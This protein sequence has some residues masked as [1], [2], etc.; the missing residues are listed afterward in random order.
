[1]FLNDLL[2]Q[3]KNVHSAKRQVSLIHHHAKDHDMKSNKNRLF[4]KDWLI[5]HMD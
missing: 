3:G 4:Y 2:P 1:M 5:S